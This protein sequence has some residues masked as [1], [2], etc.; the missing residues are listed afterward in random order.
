MP[1]WFDDPIGPAMK[2]DNPEAVLL[3]SV[4]QSLYTG[5]ARSYLIKQ[6]IPY[7]ERAPQP[8]LYQL[9]KKIG[10]GSMPTIVFP[11]GRIIRDGVAIVD[12]FEERSGHP[13]KPP[14]PCQH[15]VSLLFD[16]LGAE[17]L[18]R[19][20]MHYRFNFD[21]EQHD[22]I[23]YHF[24]SQMN[25]DEELA[26]K[27]IA[28]VSTDVAPRWGIRPSTL[29]ITEKLYEGFVEKFNAHLTQYP[30]LLGGKPCLGD[31]GLMCPLY[32]HLG[33]DP[34]PHRLL[35]MRGP[36]VH[37]WVER[38]NRPEPDTG[39]YINLPHSFLQDDEVPET[40][41]E[42]L[43]HSA[44]DFVPETIASHSGINR[45]LEENKPAIGAQCERY[46]GEAEFD[47]EGTAIHV[48]PQPFRFYLLERVQSAIQAL[49]GSDQAD[50]LAL[51]DT[52]NMT[53]VLDLK[54]DRKIGRANNLEVWLD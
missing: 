9:G 17:G 34:V 13:A 43:T 54:L 4:A 44:L 50:A 2:P 16:V 6:G 42:L 8:Y 39:E 28:H 26:K 21:E 7:E 51:L 31:F 19:P 45:W 32:G 35:Q 20:A 46:A 23:L 15:I 41:I 36:W 49:K 40:I 12:F 33:R 29:A 48:F 47:V 52:C 22:F 53:A 37:R 27:V 5:R 18:G 14:G 11:G 25:G 10:R 24:T 38:M 3:Y 1:S 30:Y